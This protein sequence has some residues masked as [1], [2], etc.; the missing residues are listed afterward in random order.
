MSTLPCVTLDGM[1]ARWNTGAAAEVVVANAPRRCFDLLLRCCVLYGDMV[2]WY[3]KTI[4]D[5]FSDIV[6][7]FLDK[8]RLLSAGTYFK[9][10]WALSEMA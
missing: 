8:M 10:G 5:N 7:L 2:R 4:S 3:Y 1:L 6:H 9:E